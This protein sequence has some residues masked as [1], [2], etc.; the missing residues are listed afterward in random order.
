MTVRIAAIGLTSW[1]KIIVTDHYPEAGSYAIVRKSLEQSGG[2]TANTAHALSSLGVPVTLAAMVGDDEQGI[3]LRDDLAGAGCDVRYVRVRIG[4]PSDT[5]VI[6]VSGL[7]GESD[8]TIFWQQGARLRMGD[9]LP[10]NEL[11][12]HDLVILDVDDE[13]LRR[14]IVDLPLH[15]APRTRI[16]GTLTYLPELPPRD[17]LDIALRYNYLVGNERELRYVTRTDA[18]DQALTSLRARMP[19]ADTRLAAISLGA[20]GCVIMTLDETI[21]VPGY[22]V[23]VVDTT[24]AGDAFAAGV[25]LGIVNNRPLEQIGKIGNALGALSIRAL[26]ARAGLPTRDELITFLG[27]D[28]AFIQAEP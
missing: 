6:V 1:D 14:F 8:R 13:R 28:S 17:A 19:G 3:Q 26:G 18:T 5:G 4:E 15:V 16:L 10:I 9:A 7:L 21:Y 24:G 11:F 23:D 27:D 25:A 22:K 12:E 2:T 20:R